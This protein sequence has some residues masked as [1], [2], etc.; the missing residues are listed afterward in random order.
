MA[1]VRDENRAKQQKKWPII[2]FFPDD[3]GLRSPS[4]FAKTFREKSA[5]SIVARVG[6]VP[7]HI[8]ATIGGGI[9]IIAVSA[10]KTFLS[11]WLTDEGVT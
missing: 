11:D 9:L 8:K 2:F 1:S 3:F 4:S 5:T 6:P 7:Y 10:T